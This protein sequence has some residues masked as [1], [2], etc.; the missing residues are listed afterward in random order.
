MHLKNLHSSVELEKKSTYSNIVISGRTVQ[1]EA[2]EGVKDS[3]DSG[4]T[5]GIAHSCI[6][7]LHS[8]K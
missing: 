5:S 2:R 1:N 6:S 7:K 3:M 8:A 4:D